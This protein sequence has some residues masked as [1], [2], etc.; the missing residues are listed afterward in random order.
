MASIEAQARDLDC[1]GD[2]D[3]GVKLERR[4]GTLMFYFGKLQGR[5]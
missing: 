5:I 4:K 1:F 3:L 2:G